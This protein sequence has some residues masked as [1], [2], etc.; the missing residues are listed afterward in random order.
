M[1]KKGF[2]QININKLTARIVG[3]EIENLNKN[4]YKGYIFISN[5]T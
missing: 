3:Y 5:A 2:P 1:N 4:I